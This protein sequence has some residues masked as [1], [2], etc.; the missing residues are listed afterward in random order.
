MLD[1]PGEEE[2]DAIGIE[3]PHERSHSERGALGRNDL[4]PNHGA[5]PESR[6]GHDFG[7]VVADVE[8]LARIAMSQ[9]LD[10]HRPVDPG[11]GMPAPIPD[12]LT[13]H[14]LTL[15]QLLCRNHDIR[16]DAW[17]RV[18][19]AEPLE[20]AAPLSVTCRTPVTG[21]TLAPRLGRCDPGPVGGGSRRAEPRGHAHRP[22]SE[23][24][25]MACP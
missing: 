22:R 21:Q 14:R 7:A 25:E 12:V 20:F 16:G 18:R 17:L 2:G 3:A 10:H 8:D 6:T 11:S 13:G 19:L 9:R 4:Q 1:A 23:R 5:A 24:S 15:G